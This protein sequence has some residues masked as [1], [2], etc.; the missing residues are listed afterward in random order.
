V[1]GGG[2]SGKKGLAG[3]T[4]G[5]HWERGGAETVQ[6]ATSSYEYVAFRPSIGGI[7]PGAVVS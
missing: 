6:A 5:V 1:G 2:A 4:S 7:L 3:R